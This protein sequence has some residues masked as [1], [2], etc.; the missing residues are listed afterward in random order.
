MNL[1]SQ[2][3][4]VIQITPEGAVRVSVVGHPGA[5]THVRLLLLERADQASEL[6]GQ[7][8]EVPWWQFAPIIRHLSTVTALFP[9][10]RVEADKASDALIRR[11]LQAQTAYESVTPSSKTTAT[12]LKRVLKE[13]GFSRS[14]TKHQ[15]RNVLRLIDMPHGATFSVPGAG[16]TTEAL[17]VFAYRTRLKVPLIVVCPKNAFSAWDEQVRECLP[18]LS[19]VRLVGG[20]SSVSR[21]LATE[22]SVAVITYS[23]LVNVVDI[24]GAYLTRRPAAL[25]LDESHKIKGGEL[26]RWP[27]AVLSLSA[28]PQLKLIMSGT[29]MPNGPEDLLPQLRFLYPTIPPDTDPVL[30]IQRIYVRTTK[31]EL[32]LPPVESKGT[33]IPLTE[34][35]ARIYRLCATEVAREAEK[36]LQSSD[37]IALRSFGRSYLLL[38]QLVSNPSLLAGYQGRFGDKDLADCLQSDS[39]KI[40]YVCHRARQLVSKG[41]K[42]LIW[43]SFVGNVEIISE[44][45]AD[46]GADFIHGDVEAGNEEEENTRE[47]KVARFHDDAKARVLVANPAACSEGISLHK[48]CHYA[49]YVDRNYNAAQFLQSADR[50][51]RLGLARDQKTYLEFIYTPGTIDDSVNRRLD[52][53]IDQME[54]ALRD[55]SIRIATHWRAD[56]EELPDAD[57]IRDLLQTLRGNEV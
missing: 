36:A 24:V 29:P 30:G 49:I 31:A 10:I 16:K 42:V 18:N 57:D 6:G 12:D 5:W 15:L 51:H 4:L 11:S 45:L 48:V 55:P 25:F 53:K 54:A 23:Q 39:P 14:L 26:R 50:I 56:L 7:V 38:L 41:H 37:R 8:I 2:P 13:L 52:F 32:G 1:K 34:A 47:Y 17:A 22:I 9:G 40:A 28:L 44:R 43:S 33:P 20:R 21:I 27:A 46:L 35:Q 3:K 19:V